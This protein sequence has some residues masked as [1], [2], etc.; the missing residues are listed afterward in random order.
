MTTKIK[1]CALRGEIAPR[2]RRPADRQ[3][4]Q[5]FQQFQLHAE[6]QALALAVRLRVLGKSL[7]AGCQ[8]RGIPAGKKAQ[9]FQSLRRQLENYLVFLVGLGFDKQPYF[10]PVCHYLQDSLPLELYGCSGTYCSIEQVETLISLLSE[11]IRG[12][13]DDFYEEPVSPISL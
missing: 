3:T 10:S 11:G 5:A 2:S 4:A 9:D 7:S 6:E 1:K 8:E 12:K 13:E